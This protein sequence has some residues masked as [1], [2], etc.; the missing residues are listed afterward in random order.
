[1][2]E[3]TL[4]TVHGRF[5]LR[6]S[7]RLNDLVTGVIGRAQKKY[8][9]RIHGI[10]V[11]SNHLHLAVTPDSPQQLAAFMDYVAGN[12]AREVGRLHDWREKFWARRY[13]AIV[14][15]DEEEAQAGRLAYLLGQGVKEGLVERPQHWPG[16]HCAAALL[17]GATLVGTW[18]DRTALYEA[19]RRGESKSPVHF[20]ETE[21]V[22]FTPLPCWAHLEPAAYRGRIAALIRGIIEDGRRERAGR[23]VLGRR[24]ILAQPPH[25]KPLHSDRSPAPLVHA[26]T[27]AVRRMLRAAYVEFVAAFREAARRLRCGDRLVRFPEGAFPPPLP[28]VIPT[29]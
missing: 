15:S 21:E 23:P 1:M 25:D 12:V 4:R 27:R 24:A 18:V 3:V 26:A 11:L 5:L 16:V 14:V 7:P 10:A 8:G 17:A 2:V 13:R 19:R 22:V 20:T 28:C 9:L 6:P 29:G